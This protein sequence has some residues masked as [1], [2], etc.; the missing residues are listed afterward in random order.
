MNKTVL[1]LIERAGRKGMAKINAYYTDWYGNSEKTEKYRVVNNCNEWSLYHYDT[2]TATVKNG[3]GKVV[4]G[5]SRSD[6]DSIQT[7]L[8]ELTG[9]APEMHYYPSKEVFQVL[10]DGK[11]VQSF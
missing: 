1:T 8:I 5:Q 10:E 6:L 9:K 4:W 11:V 2:L 3:I 7:F